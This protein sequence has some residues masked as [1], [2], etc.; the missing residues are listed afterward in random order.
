VFSEIQGRRK[1]DIVNVETVGAL[2]SLAQCYVEKYCDKGY[3][4]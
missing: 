4:P 1:Y 3:C 2:L